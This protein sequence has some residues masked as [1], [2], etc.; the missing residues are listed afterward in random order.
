MH[1]KVHVYFSDD[2]GLV[3]PE[4]LGLV[5]PEDLG[6]VAPEDLGLVAHLSIVLFY[7]VAPFISKSYDILE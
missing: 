3:A 5:A 2:L 1:K 4:D 6:L 7:E